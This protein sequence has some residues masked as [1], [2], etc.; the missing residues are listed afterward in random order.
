MTDWYF[1]PAEVRCMILGALTVHDNIA[2]YASVST[3]WRNFIEK[4]IFS[5]LRLHPLCLYRLE[6]LDDHYR[7]KV[8]HLWFNIEIGRY[9]CRSCRNR[10]SE[11]L[12]FSISRIVDQSISRLFSILKHWRSPLT[13]E[14]NVYSP[15]DSEHWFKKCYF[16][17]PEEDK[18]ECRPHS[19]GPLHDPLHGWYEERVTGAPPDDALRRPFGMSTL[20][21]RDGL[22]FVQAVNKFVLRRQCRQQL[23]AGA[24]SDLLFKFPNLEEIVYEPWLSHWQFTQ[25]MRDISFM[26]GYAS[27]INRLRKGVKKVAIFED[28]N[29]NYLDLFA[30]NRSWGSLWH[31][32][33]RVRV[34]ETKIA[35]ELNQAL[36]LRGQ[37]LEHLSVAFMVEA[38][39]F[40]EV[41]Q[42]GWQWPQLQTLTLTSREMA[43]TKG[44]RTNQLL[45]T[46]AH[47]SLSIPE[48]K[49][50]TL[51]NG[52][53]GEACSFTYSRE[54]SSIAWRGTWDL[55]L[56]HSIIEAWRNVAYKHS[57]GELRVQTELLSE[58]I[59]SHGDAIHYLGLHHVVDR[60][61]L[62]Q[63]RAENRLSWL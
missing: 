4:K 2:P 45:M 23:D 3:E 19:S 27:L 7:R 30:L 62:Q 60:V 51:W 13:L 17:A 6:E 46:A 15:S 5:H 22:P 28:F 40:F 31:N 53:R 33:K 52:A 21:F 26:K 34:I 54:D 11:T 42:P 38:R 20:R 29:E 10:E 37:K 59:G 25:P 41:C 36:A 43:K 16:G 63:I 1:L 12:A 47:F 9:T 57:R 44:T 32:P 56:N 61:S 14:L 50:L 8:D 39:H 48:L 18:F 55:D 58:D 35:R 49:T 24:L